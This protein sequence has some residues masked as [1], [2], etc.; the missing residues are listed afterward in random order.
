MNFKSGFISIIGKTNVGKS[1]LLNYVLGEKIAIV[2]DKPQTTRNRILGIKNSPNAQMIFLD[3]PGIH[4]AKPQLNR[5]MVKEATKTYSDVDI[6]LLLVQANTGIGDGDRFVIE[7]LEKIKAPVVLV[8]N[9]ID[10]VEKKSL[11]PLIDQFS[12]LYDFKSIIPI[13]AL[14][15]QGVDQLIKEIKG[16]LPFGPKYFPEEM[17][18]DLPERFIVAEIIREKIFHLT[19][20]EIPYSVAVVIND[21]KEREGVNT[22]FIRAAIHVEKPSQKGILIGKKG[23]MLKRIGQLAR[24]DIENLL[25]AKVYLELLVRVE[26]D[27]SK[28]IKALRKLGYR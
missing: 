25:D 15:G 4:K 19:S 24:I 12:K 11:L 8:I 28:D 27:W 6:I 18:T 20:Q 1:T 5:Y 16:L 22:I 26:K 23:G 7:T 21:F 17:I 10:L 2:S 9:K 3:T 14:S 13:S